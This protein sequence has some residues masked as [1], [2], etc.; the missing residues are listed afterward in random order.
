MLWVKKQDYSLWILIELRPRL[1]VCLLIKT[2][3]YSL[4]NMVNTS[5]KLADSFF[6]QK[7]RL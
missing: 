1:I 4:E 5:P 7:V 2:Q 6:S 3:D